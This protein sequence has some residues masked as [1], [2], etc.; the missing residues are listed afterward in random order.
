MSLKSVKV[1]QF[2][3]Y[4]TTFLAHKDMTVAIVPVGYA[5]GFSRSLSNTGRVLI[6]GTRVAVIGIVNMNLMVIDISD[7]DDVK[8]GEKVT[9]IGKQDEMEVTV[10]SFSELSNQLNYELLT[11]LPLDIPRCILEE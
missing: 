5:H 2:V 7:I 8:I 3:G 10:A 11:R 9:M 4:G 6:K 1:G